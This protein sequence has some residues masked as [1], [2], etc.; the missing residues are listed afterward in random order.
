ML[1]ELAQKMSVFA[2]RSDLEKLVRASRCGTVTTI[3]LQSP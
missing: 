3:S 2:E 1:A